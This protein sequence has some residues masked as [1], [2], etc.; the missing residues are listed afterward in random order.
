MTTHDKSD[1]AGLAGQAPGRARDLPTP[2]EA[3][4]EARHLRAARAQDG[5]PIGHGQAL[6]AVAHGHGFRDWN[7][8]AAAIGALGPAGLRAGDRVTGRYL[9]QPFRATVLSAEALR[10]GWVRLEL[11]L[12]EAVDVVTFESFSNWR[13]RVRAEVGPEGQSRARRSDG[14][15]HMV[16]E[17]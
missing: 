11:D 15:P 9:S 6:E 7:T 2:A 12:D 16:L 1:T 8:M 10:P 17:L 4:A 13:K 5:Q 14:T 3:K